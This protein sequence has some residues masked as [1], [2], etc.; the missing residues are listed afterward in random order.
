MKLAAFCCFR[1]I[2]VGTSHLLEMKL[3]L[4]KTQGNEKENDRILTK[5][6]AGKQ[7]TSKRTRK[8]TKRKG[9]N[10]KPENCEGY[11]T[12]EVSLFALVHVYWN[13]METQLPD[14]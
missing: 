8:A 14:N 5:T 3:N 13:L 2:R 12:A 1:P 10:I 4:C 6:Q 7:N 9:T 11:Q